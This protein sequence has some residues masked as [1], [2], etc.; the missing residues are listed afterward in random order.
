MFL[1][2]LSNMILPGIFNTTYE[3]CSCTSQDYSQP[4]KFENTAMVF[5]LTT[6]LIFTVTA[7]RIKIYKH[8]LKST[9][10]PIDPNQVLQSKFP[11]KMLAD[12]TVTIGSALL[13]MAASSIKYI[14]GSKHTTM[15]L[16]TMHLFYLLALPITYNSF[17]ILFYAKNAQARKTILR[18]LKGSLIQCNQ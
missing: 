5:S 8:R 3:M 9:S 13:F 2:N 14:V 18:E 11:T 17:T 4:K 7:V 16:K 15:D 1:I 12:L 10:A 6:L